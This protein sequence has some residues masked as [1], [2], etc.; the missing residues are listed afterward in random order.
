MP[1]DS[2]EQ[3]RHDLKRPWDAV[4]KHA[5]LTGVRLHDLR[6]TY[7]TLVPVEDWDYRSLADCWDTR[8][9]PRLRD[10]HIWITTR[11]GAHQRQSPGVLQQR[12][13]EAEMREYIRFARSRS[14]L[15]FVDP[16]IRRV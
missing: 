13:M 4:T 15:L 3:P 8:R 5:G 1:G 6:H 16:G 11:Y 14:H 2:P 12:W 7:A 10:M 9:R